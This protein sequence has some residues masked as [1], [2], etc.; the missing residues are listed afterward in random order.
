MVRTSA[1]VDLQNALADHVLGQGD[2]RDFLSAHLA[3]SPGWGKAERLSLHRNTSLI[4][5]TEAL[6]AL[7]PVVARLVGAAFFGHLC[8][9]F[10]ASE[11]PQTPVLYRWGEG[12][13]K[14]IAPREDCASVP[15]LADVAALE[16]ARDQARHAAEQVPLTAETLLPLAQ[17][18]VAAAEPLCLA[19][20]S[21][22]QLLVSPWPIFSLWQA[23]Q[24]DEPPQMTLDQ[25]ENVVV[26]RP[27]GRIEMRMVSPATAAFLGALADGE[28][29]DRAHQKGLGLSRGFDFNTCLAEGLQAGW[30]AP[31]RNGAS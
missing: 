14:A 22:A 24:Q 1:L 18:A 7:Y 20:H 16:W 17:Q 12:F 27:Y 13:S 29:L 30:F 9:D 5:L 15:Y 19:L 31:E 10:I 2:R 3:T 25:G 21:S 6:E 4:T 26:W 23:H 11:P 28:D 8:K